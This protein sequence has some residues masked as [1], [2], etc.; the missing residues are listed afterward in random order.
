M[1]NTITPV[2][3]YYRS[4]LQDYWRTKKWF[5]IILTITLVWAI[6]RLILQLVFIFSGL[7]GDQLG[8]DLQVYLKAAQ[9]FSQQLDLYPQNLKVLEEHFPYPPV[10]AF[11]FI[12]FLWLPQQ[13][14]IVVHFLL[15]IV[16][17]FLLFFIWGRIF[18]QWK[19]EGA[20]RLLILTLPVWLVF[21]AFWDDVNYL[22]VYM[23]MALLG[24]LLIEAVLNEKL[25]LSVTWLTLILI[26]KPQWAFAALVPLFLGRYRFFFK[27]VL[28]SLLSYFL[29]GLITLIAGGPAYVWQ[30]Y[31]DYVNL[32]VRLGN[33]FPWRGPDSGF[34]GSNH[35]I[36][37]ILVFLLGDRPSILTLATFIKIV[38]LVPLAI[39]AIRYIIKPLRQ[40]DLRMP[41]TLELALLMY[42]GAF[43]WLDIVWEASL[44]IVLFGY[45][46]SV[47]ISKLEK[48]IV[49]AVFLPYAILDLWRVLCYLAG[50]PMINDSYL[51]W[52]YSIYLPIIMLV[53]LAFY[54]ILSYRLWPWRKHS[55]TG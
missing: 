36:K 22:N 19:L 48:G 2:V 26:T 30:Q 14:A 46:L 7:A 40:A 52:D 20:S 33:E 29:L 44:G 39:I 41:Q 27:M 3:A 16:V 51:S 10:F 28:Y 17:Y 21:S 12:P 47:D 4:I 54:A 23:L 11:L 6:L 35:S 18:R 45:L 15:H 8:I 13:A 42:L 32:L 53:I 49:V 55:A 31:R 43:I 38:L 1:A 37:Q 25:V 9:H 50:A 34:L 5:R 24:T